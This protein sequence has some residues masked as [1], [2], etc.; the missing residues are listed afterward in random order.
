MKT[1]KCKFVLVQNNNSSPSK[2]GVWKHCKTNELALWQDMFSVDK[3]WYGFDLILI[4]LDPEE[5]IKV[6]DKCYDDGSRRLN[7]DSGIYNVILICDNG[8]YMLEHI[9]TKCQI[10]VRSNIKKVIATQSQISLADIQKAIE[11]YN[12]NGEFEDV[13][14]EMEAV[15]N[16]NDNPFTNPEGLYDFEGNKWSPKL[17]NGFV[18][19]SFIKKLNDDIESIKKEADKLLE[20]TIEAKKKSK[21]IIYTETEVKELCMKVCAHSIALK[22]QIADFEDFDNFFNKNKKK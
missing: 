12:A 17:T 5:K 22:G 1:K 10:F 9:V 15:S 7:Y 13:E 6:E 8:D 2:I 20:E 16:E 19:I 14:I 3:N 4:S 18:T 11:Q 21:P